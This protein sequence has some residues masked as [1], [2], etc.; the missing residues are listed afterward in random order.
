MSVQMATSIVFQTVQAPS[1][2]C[3]DVVADG[4]LVGHIDRSGEEYRYFEGVC[5]EVIWSFA[6]SDLARLQSRIRA[7]IAVRRAPARPPVAHAGG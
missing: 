2:W 5:N 6:D 1:R 4:V 3:T 7:S